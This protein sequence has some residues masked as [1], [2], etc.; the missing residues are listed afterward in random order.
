MANKK[1]AKAG[2]AADSVRSNPYVQRLIEHEDL[3]AFGVQTMRAYGIVG[4]GDAA[5]LGI[6]TMSDARWKQTF[7]F[8]VKAGLLKPTVDYRKAYSLE[9]VRDVRVL[10]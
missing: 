2:K 4:G 7:D 10:P 3:L 6:M 5:K 8:M 1:V 9:Y